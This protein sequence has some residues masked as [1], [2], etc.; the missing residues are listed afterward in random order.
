MRT[1]TWKSTERTV[2]RRLNCRRVGP[3]GTS[4]ADAVNEWLSVE[5][6]HKKELPGW[7]KAAMNQSVK[8]ATPGQLPLVVLHELGQRHDNDYVVMRMRDY[9]EWYGA[10]TTERPGSAL[11]APDDSGDE[12][13]QQPRNGAAEDQDDTG[14]CCGARAECTKLYTPR[15]VGGEG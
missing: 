14:D 12:A 3:S 11:S 4:T 1:D 5:V 6:K 2:A 7:L 9:Q 8:A 10:P 15:A 13:L